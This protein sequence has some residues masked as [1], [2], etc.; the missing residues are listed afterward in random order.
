MP[1]LPMSIQPENPKVVLWHWDEGTAW[2]LP[3]LEAHFPEREWDNMSEGRLCE[4][5]AV[6]CA[7]TTLMGE[8]GWRVTHRSG[9]PQLHSVSGASL[10]LS[11]SHH[12]TGGNTAAAVAVWGAGERSHGIDLVDT[13]DLRIL[14]I[15]GRFMSPDEQTRWPNAKPWV[16]AAKEAMFKGHGPNLDFQRDLSVDSMT[17]EAECGQLVGTVR[18]ARWRGTC[19]HV[20][21]STLGV[22]WSS[23]F[24][25]DLG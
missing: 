2:P 15:S 5:Q 19:A 24:A 9:K 4:H 1:R 6:A 22:V 8:E 25:Q 23:P 18:G 13:T 21:H 3:K 10:P 12:S 20:P 11:I 16:W 7:L 14:R 17:W